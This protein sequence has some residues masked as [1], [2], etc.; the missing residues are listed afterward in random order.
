VIYA[1]LNGE[2]LIM[3]VNDRH[4]L[5]NQ[6]LNPGTGRNISASYYNQAGSEV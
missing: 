5:K 4:G 3:T 6:V 1:P 2:V